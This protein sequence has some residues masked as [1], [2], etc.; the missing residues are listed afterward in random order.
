MNI[1]KEIAETDGLV[2]DVDG[3]PYPT[4]PRFRFPKDFLP[5][6]VESVSKGNIRAPLAYTYYWC[7]KTGSRSRLPSIMFSGYHAVAQNMRESDYETSGKK[8][9]DVRVDKGYIK[10]LD[11]FIEARKPVVVCSRNPAVKYILRPPHI[12]DIVSNKLV[13][14]EN[15]VFERVD[16]NILDGNDKRNELE[17]YLRSNY[18]P[19]ENWTYIGDAYQDIP[20]GRGAKVFLASPYANGRCK[21]EATV[22][23]DYD[24]FARNLQREMPKVKP[25]QI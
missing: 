9:F 10:F 6:L 21:K 18:S 3:V 12:T 17:S 16:M 20:S 24:N 14:D 23:N 19:L 25:S 11:T 5:F 15:G 8:F 2:T 7:S 22:I 4:V 1:Y 13:F